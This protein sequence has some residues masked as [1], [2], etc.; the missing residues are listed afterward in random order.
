MKYVLLSP[1]L[2]GEANAANTPTRNASLSAELILDADK[3]ERFHLLPER[4]DDK[5]ENTTSCKLFVCAKPSVTLQSY[6]CSPEWV[7]D[8]IA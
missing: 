6:S 4:T 1:L 2:G 7:Q 3:Q 5:D 8:R